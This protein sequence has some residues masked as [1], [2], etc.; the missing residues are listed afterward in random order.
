MS[1]SQEYRESEKTAFFQ[2]KVYEKFEDVEDIRQEWDC[3][4]EDVCSDIFMTYDWCRIWWKYYGKNRN[5]K[6]YLFRSGNDLVGVVPLFIERIWLGPIYIDAVKIIGSDFVLSHFA[7]PIR[8][9]FLDKVVK[10][11]FNELQRFNWD[12]LHLGPVAGKSCISRSAIKEFEL[13]FGRVFEVTKYNGNVQICFDLLGSWDDYL[14]KLAKKDRQLMKS[15]YKKIQKADLQIHVEYADED[16]YEE[17]FE[18]FVEIHQNYWQSKNR[19]GHF[20]DWPEAKEFHRE[21]AKAQLKRGRLRLLR[22]GLSDDCCAYQYSYAC[23]NE[24]YEMLTGRSFSKRLAHIDLGRLI[25]AEQAKKALEENI[26][27]IDSMRGMYDY[28]I[29]LG[30]NIFPLNNIILSRRKNTCL[31]RFFIFRKLAKILDLCYYRIC[32]CRLAKKLSLKNI[33]LARIWVRTKM[34]AG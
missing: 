16:N 29:R 30:G 33:S 20:G 11:L 31:I 12:V 17:M 24:Y 21:V 25:F 4:I 32:Y 14:A 13:Q 6:I 19:P 2:I 18:A 1:M 27:R 26:D 5:L 22:V 34:F 15:T 9:R 3:F 23:G 8:K 28:K 7:L 10:G